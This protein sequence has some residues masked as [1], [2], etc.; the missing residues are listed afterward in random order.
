MIG[1]RA[2]DCGFLIVPGSKY[3]ELE[4]H[5][6]R[7]EQERLVN[8]ILTGYGGESGSAQC[9]CHPAVDFL[10][11]VVAIHLCPPHEF[12][13]ETDLPGR[14]VEWTTPSSLGGHGPHSY[15]ALSNTVSRADRM[16]FARRMRGRWEMQEGLVQHC[17]E[18]NEVYVGSIHRCP[19]AIQTTEGGKLW[20]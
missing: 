18:C 15:G 5:G 11:N 16:V 4:F 19:S 13:N 9:K 7:T 1:G 17:E 6:T 12:L 2:Q 8:A 20:W 3:P 14:S 10:G